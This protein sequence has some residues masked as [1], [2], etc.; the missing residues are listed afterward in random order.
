VT[1]TASMR[2]ALEALAREAVDLVVSDIAMP[3]GSGY[4]RIA[5]IRAEPRTATL[6]AVAITAY[7]RP[8]DRERVLD[9]GFDAHVGKPLDPR[10]LIGL[11]AQ[12]SRAS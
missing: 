8:E 12:L 4:D 7:V 3:N 6:T 10:A 11:L 5:A 1:G 2:E 9:A